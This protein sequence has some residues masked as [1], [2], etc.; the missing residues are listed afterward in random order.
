MYGD[1]RAQP[2]E[3]YPTSIGIL[4]ISN[5]LNYKDRGVYRHNTNV[6]WGFE[7]DISSLQVNV[8]FH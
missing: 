2:I 7:L 1:G 3:L 8:I 6:L 5:S 4:N